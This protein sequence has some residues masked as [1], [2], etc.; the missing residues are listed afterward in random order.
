MCEGNE[1]R[2]LTGLQAAEYLRGNGYALIL[3]GG[4][5]GQMQVYALGNDKHLRFLTTPGGKRR[6]RT[7]DLDAFLAKWKGEQQPQVAQQSQPA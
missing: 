1:T 7:D 3:E 4:R 5:R 2:I 6:Y